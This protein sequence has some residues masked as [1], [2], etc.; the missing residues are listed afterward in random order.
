M[1]AGDSSTAL[2]KLVQVADAPSPQSWPHHGGCACKRAHTLAP[3]PTD[4]R[5]RAHRKAR[6]CAPDTAA[7]LRARGPV[8]T[9]LVLSTSQVMRRHDD[10]RGGEKVVAADGVAAPATGKAAGRRPAA[11]D[12]R[13]SVKEG[14]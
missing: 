10:E 9:P 3:Q 4:V 5:T 12:G 6:T 14:G 1:H 13:G 2:R 11:A 8:L 7:T